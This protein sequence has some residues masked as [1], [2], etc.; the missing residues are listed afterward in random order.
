MILDCSAKT[1][2]LGYPSLPPLILMSTPSL[3]LKRVISYLCPY[4]MMGKG[5]LSSCTRLKL[6]VIFFGVH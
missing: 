6:G 1:V 5:Y 4:H 2:T 3:Y